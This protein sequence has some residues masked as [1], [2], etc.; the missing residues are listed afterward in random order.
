MTGKRLLDA[1]AIFQASRGVASKH[2]ALRK[3]QLVAFNKTSTLA[4][5]AKSQIERVTLTVKA[6]SALAG[7]FNEPGSAYSSQTSKLG[8]SSKDVSIP[9]EKS[10]K[11]A[12]RGEQQKQGL[13]QDHFCERSE[14]NATTEPPQAGILDVKQEEAKNSALPDGSIPAAGAFTSIL[15]PD[16]KYDSEL[17]RMETGTVL[18]EEQTKG[19][20]EDIQHASSGRT[21]IPEP[22]KKLSPLSAYELMRLQR[23]AEIQIPSQAAELP[24]ATPPGIEGDESGLK[25]RQGQEAL[26]T[27]SKSSGQVLSGLPRVEIPMKAEDTQES[28]EHV[29]DAE[30]NQDV[31]YSATS[32]SKKQTIPEAQ[33]VPEQGQISDEAYSEIFHSPRVAK[34]LRGQSEKDGPLKGLDL[35]GAKHMPLEETKASGESDE[36]SS[37]VRISAKNKSE[38]SARSPSA[39]SAASGG[40]GD[41][42]VRVLASDVAKDTNNI[43]S[44][45]SEVNTEFI[46]IKVSMLIG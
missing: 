1:A 26:Y 10:V 11:G 41:V 36:I 34:M 20:A 25:V 45:T 3:N 22:A 28:D 29:S 17:P 32:K 27:A 43:S 46:R 16:N 33:A 23:Q 13:D 35:P 8:P 37:S 18:Q 6:A 40:N 21:S 30:M 9:R 24:N 42:D 39:A 4:K 14:D 2:V 15:N 31:F 7:R 19:R 12:N 5:A 44:N 38:A